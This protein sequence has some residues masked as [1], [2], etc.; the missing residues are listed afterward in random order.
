MKAP[1]VGCRQSLNSLPFH[2]TLLFSDT[3]QEFFMIIKCSRPGRSTEVYS[4]MDGQ[5]VLKDFVFV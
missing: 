5:L 3:V 1:T 4:N 2:I